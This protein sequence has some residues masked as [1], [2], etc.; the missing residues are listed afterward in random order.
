MHDVP[1]A[2]AHLLTPRVSRDD[3]NVKDERKRRCVERNPGILKEG[4][5]TDEPEEEKEKTCAAQQTHA[6]RPAMAVSAG[7]CR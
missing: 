6:A 2:K 1:R 5:C 7:R 3:R 4:A